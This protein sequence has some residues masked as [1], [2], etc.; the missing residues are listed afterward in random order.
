MT[1]IVE[2]PVAMG[3]MSDETTDYPCHCPSPSIP[4]IHI[5]ESLDET[6]PEQ[7]EYQRIEGTD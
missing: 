7:I 6:A 5:V 1:T 3:D 2:S 4:L